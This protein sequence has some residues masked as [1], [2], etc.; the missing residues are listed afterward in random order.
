MKEIIIGALLSGEHDTLGCLWS[1][2][3]SEH[4]IELANG[5][6]QLILIIYCASL[7]LP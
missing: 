1:F 7:E 3:V 6:N 2:G 5:S 4:S